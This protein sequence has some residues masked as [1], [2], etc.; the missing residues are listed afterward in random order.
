MFIGRLS[1]NVRSN[2]TFARA[3]RYPAQPRVF[4]LKPGVIFTTSEFSGPSAVFLRSGGTFKTKYFFA[5][6]TS[7][8][9]TPDCERPFRR[10]QV[11]SS[12]SALL[13]TA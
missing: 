7:L 4:T 2:R 11:K 1:I 8:I 5:I 13:L 9:Q 6:M 10:R 3:A 12:L